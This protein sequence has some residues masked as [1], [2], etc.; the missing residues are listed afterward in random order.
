ML[1]MFSFGVFLFGLSGF[2]ILKMVKSG[3]SF[4]S[5]WP[6]LTF[7]FYCQIQALSTVFDPPVLLP[8]LR[9]GPCS[10]NLVLCCCFYTFISCFLKEKCHKYVVYQYLKIGGGRLGDC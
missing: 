10:R 5:H 2:L 6:P 3:Q 7:L 9:G 1:G 8:G 4:I